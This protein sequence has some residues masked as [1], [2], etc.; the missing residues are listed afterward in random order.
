MSGL[1]RK[2]RVD[3]VRMRNEKEVAHSANI[4]Q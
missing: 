3:Q 4:L 2:A 1:D